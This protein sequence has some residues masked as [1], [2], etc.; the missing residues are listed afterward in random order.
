MLLHDGDD[1][2]VADGRAGNLTALRAPGEVLWAAMHPSASRLAT[3][4]HLGVVSLW[5]T[6]TGGE[7]ARSAEGIADDAGAIAYAPDGRHIVV[8]D[9]VGFVRQLD[10]ETLKAQVM[11]KLPL[12]GQALGIRA[13]HGGVIAVTADKTRGSLLDHGGLRGRRRGSRHS[14]S[15]DRCVGTSRQLQSRRSAVRVPVRTMAQSASWKS[16]PA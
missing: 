15:G 8:V 6:T 1:W 9:R 2:L 16:R 10:A 11:I 14:G 4:D 3:V 13:T 12:T 5:D 7:L